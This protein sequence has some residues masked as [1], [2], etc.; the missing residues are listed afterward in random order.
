MINRIINILTGKTEKGVIPKHYIRRYLPPAPI[1]VEAGAHIG[2]DSIE[3]AKQWPNGKIYAFE[4]VS[5]IFQQLKSNT[6]S[7][8]NIRPIKLALSD[9]NGFSD[10]FISGGRSDG[11]SSLLAPKEHLEIHPDVTFDHKAK[12]KTVTLDTWSQRNKIDHIDFLW[13]DLQGLELQVL[14]ASEEILKKVRAIYTEVSLVEN[15]SNGALYPELR[16][17]LE[18]RGFVVIKESLP[19][20]DG[21]NVLFVKMRPRV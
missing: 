18:G 3:L 4:P 20:D 16:S 21:G 11:S 7:Y 6:V 1:V 9:H 8:K 12:I 14:K 10:I 19:W 5:E 13:L 15:Y 2:L 17:W